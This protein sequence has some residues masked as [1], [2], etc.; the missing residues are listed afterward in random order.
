M[1]DKVR[2]RLYEPGETIISLSSKA[3]FDVAFD[4]SFD[5]FVFPCLG[6][7]SSSSKSYDDDFFCFFLSDWLLTSYVNV[8]FANLISFPSEL[9]NLISIVLSLR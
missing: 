8:E 9:T 6:V 1:F 7:S 5:F 2:V 4:S 3:T